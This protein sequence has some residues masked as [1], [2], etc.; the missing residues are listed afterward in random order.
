MEIKKIEDIYP[1]VI[2]LNRNNYK[3]IIFNSHND[4][5]YVTTACEDEEVSWYLEDY[6]EKTL[7][8]Y[9]VNYGIGDDIQ[10]AFEDYKIRN[11]K[12]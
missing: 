1:L 5:H 12:Q 2:V 7:P 8:N 6:L 3:I 9:N 11:L 10:S 4:A